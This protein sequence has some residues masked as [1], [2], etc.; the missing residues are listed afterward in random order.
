MSKIQVEANSQSI[1]KSAGLGVSG[2]SLEFWLSQLL[3]VLFWECFRPPIKWRDLKVGQA[4]FWFLFFFKEGWE[5]QKTKIEAVQ[6]DFSLPF[7]SAKCCIKQYPEVPSLFLPSTWR[8][9]S[10]TFHVVQGPGADQHSSL[11]LRQTVFGDRG[12]GGHLKWTFCWQ[13]REL[14]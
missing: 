9:E 13:N 2:C 3:L 4:L 8:L 11:S 14:S 5:W 1:G 12:V 7:C 10:S 6:K